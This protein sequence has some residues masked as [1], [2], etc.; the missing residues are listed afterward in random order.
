VTNWRWPP[1]LAEVLPRM[2][3]VFSPEHPKRF[4]ELAIVDAIARSGD[5][6]IPTKK[7]DEI[8]FPSTSLADASVEEATRALDDLV[9]HVG[10]MH[11]RISA[12]KTNGVWLAHR[13]HV[14]HFCAALRAFPAVTAVPNFHYRIRPLAPS[15]GVG[16]IAIH[17][18][19]FR[20][21][22]KTASEA[23]T[24]SAAIGRAVEECVRRLGMVTPGAT[25]PTV[26]HY[27]SQYLLAL[28]KSLDLELLL[29]SQALERL[30]KASVA[31]KLAFS[32]SGQGI[33]E[34]AASVVSSLPLADVK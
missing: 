15:I 5:L 19:A 17:D 3:A 7:M 26:S 28:S 30:A 33:F 21:Y 23:Q 24:A 11:A 8:S 29:L 12:R 6:P 2:T 25:V 14:T 20:E 27:P 10:A 34:A 9:W 22:A 13:Q 16:L 1:I 32:R 18:A 31:H 4:L